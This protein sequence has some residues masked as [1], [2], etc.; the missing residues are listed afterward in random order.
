MIQVLV[1]EPK[2]QTRLHTY[3]TVLKVE[4]KKRL[5]EPLKADDPVHYL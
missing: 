3:N 5:P 1:Q 4:R 2:I